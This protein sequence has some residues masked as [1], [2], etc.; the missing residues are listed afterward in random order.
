M[1]I[2]DGSSTLA[3]QL[4]ASAVGTQELRPDT[5][6]GS[7]LLLSGTIRR[8]PRV[9]SAVA[10]TSNKIRVTFDGQMANDS[11]LLDRTNYQVAP[12]GP[13]V[14]VVVSSVQP[15]PGVTYP[16]WVELATTEM[17]NGATYEVEVNTG[18]GSPRDR[19]G[20]TVNLVGNVASFTG[21]GTAPFIVSVAAAGRNRADVKFSEPM[22]DDG[23]DIRDP[24]SYV[25]DGGLTTLAV[26][27]VVGDTVQ[28][29]TS[30]QTPGQLYNLT[31]N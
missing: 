31:I 22:L 14:A 21:L 10:V 26:L 18:A 2:V 4:T 5:V 30:D 24:A 23:G 29:V 6:L 19:Y 13:G 1:A 15:Q 17:T 12:T 25:W 8:S 3:I 16:T 27:G 20:F 9:A 7:V 11:R 28:L